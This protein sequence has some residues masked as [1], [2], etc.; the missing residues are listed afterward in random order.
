MS[1]IRLLRTECAYDISL[2]LIGSPSNQASFAIKLYAAAIEYANI[3]FTSNND[4]A[5]MVVEY[6]KYSSSYDT[7]FD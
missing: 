6:C 1:L 5:M 2:S 3:N 4:V 7:E